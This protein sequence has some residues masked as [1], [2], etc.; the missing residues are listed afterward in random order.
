MDNTD[1]QHLPCF[2]KADPMQPRDEVELRD[3]E[4]R[5]NFSGRY[6]IFVG[7]VC[8]GAIALGDG[9]LRSA[10]ISFI[11]HLLY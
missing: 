4:P 6:L 5:D 7:I 11:K 10:L 9:E 8:I 3:K 2:A 1:T